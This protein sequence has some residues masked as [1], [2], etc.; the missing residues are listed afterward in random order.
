[1]KSKP[2]RV[3]TI[4]VPRLALVVVVLA[5]VSC[6]GKSTKDGE[7][8]QNVDR[9]GLTGEKLKDSFDG[10]RKYL[11]SDILLLSI[12]Y[13]DYVDNRM[14]KPPTQLK[15]IERSLE[16]DQPDRF[17]KNLRENIDIV[18]NAKLG[19]GPSANRVIVYERNADKDG[20]RLVVTT[21]GKLRFMGEVEFKTA[22]KNAKE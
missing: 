12:A 9:K 2:I 16:T 11:A 17:K 6:S 1:M 10:D 4:A 20:N 22:L 8:G 5:L 19:E 21:D 13:L 15:D 7:G 3:A 18:W 14:G